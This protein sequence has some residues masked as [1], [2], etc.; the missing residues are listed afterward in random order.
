MTHRE[1]LDDP[2]VQRIRDGEG[3]HDRWE[4]DRLIEHCA[5]RPHEAD[6]GISGV[7]GISA[8]SPRLKYLWFFARI[9]GQLRARADE[10]TLRLN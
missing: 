8:P 4:I 2:L 9:V 6:I 10:G 7:P 1:L 5:G 3:W